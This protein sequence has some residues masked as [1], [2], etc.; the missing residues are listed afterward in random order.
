VRRWFVKSVVKDG[1]STINVPLILTNLSKVEAG[2]MDG[3]AVK[4][5]DI[6]QNVNCEGIWLYF[7]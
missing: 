7:Y 6:I 2:G 3:V 1:C 5:I 4:C